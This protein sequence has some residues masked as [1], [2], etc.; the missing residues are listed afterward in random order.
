M[1]HIKVDIKHEPEIKIIGG[2]D[3]QTKKFKIND[4]PMNNEIDSDDEPLSRIKVEI[5]HEQQQIEFIDM[6]TIS[7]LSDEYKTYQR[8]ATE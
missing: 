1:A 3:M 7:N 8:A 4:V 2:N 6:V 5:K